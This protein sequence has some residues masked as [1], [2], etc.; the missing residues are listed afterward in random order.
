MCYN[1]ILL[2]G[3]SLEDRCKDYF[4][5]YSL[6]D[7]VCTDAETSSLNEGAKVNVFRL[8]EVFRRYRSIRT[9][10]RTPS[11]VDTFKENCK[12]FCSM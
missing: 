3:L 1:L 2:S 4:H 8:D 5:I 7:K 10:S 9:Y 6:R 12:D 11:G